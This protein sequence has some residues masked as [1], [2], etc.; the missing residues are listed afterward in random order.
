MGGA[1][2]KSAPGFCGCCAVSAGEFMA[3]PAGRGGCW[4]SCASSSRMRVSAAIRRFADSASALGGFGSFGAGRTRHRAGIRRRRRGRTRRI[5][6]LSGHQNRVGSVGLPGRT[7]VA[8][9]FPSIGPDSG[10]RCG[11]QWRP[12]GVSW[13]GMGWY[14]PFTRRSPARG[15]LWYWPPVSSKRQYSGTP[16]WA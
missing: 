15:T 12:S 1:G 7:S 9:R 14:W 13:I 11:P 16:I 5:G 8:R 10:I 2:F 4:R 6:P 3:Y